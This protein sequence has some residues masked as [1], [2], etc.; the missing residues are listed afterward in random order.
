MTVAVQYFLTSSR[1]IPPTLFF[2]IKIIL[3]ILGPDFP[4]TVHSNLD[5]P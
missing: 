2:F 3:A 4:Y 5:Y 1:V